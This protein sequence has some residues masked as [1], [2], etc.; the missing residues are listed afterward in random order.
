MKISKIESVH[1]DAEIPVYDVKD[2]QPYHNF[3]VA[4][5]DT[6]IISHN[7]MLA[8]EPGFENKEEDAAKAE[9]ADYLLN[10]SN[11][12]ARINSRFPHFPMPQM[13][14]IPPTGKRNQDVRTQIEKS[15]NNA[16]T[17]NESLWN[18]KPIE[19]YSGDR[20][21]IA[22]RTSTQSV[23]FVQ[24]DDDIPVLIRYGYEIIKVP[25]EYKSDFEFNAVLALRDLAGIN[26]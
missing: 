1:Y 11:F 19:L 3:A 16:Y 17:I 18:I 14:I 10:L 5:D 4:A 22:Y 2:V 7:C 23:E 9:K 13:F 25:V 21:T 24:D 12:R 26:I 20:F 6:L 8:D 15:Y